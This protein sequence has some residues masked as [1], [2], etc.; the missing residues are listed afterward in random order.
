MLPSHG[1]N[2]AQLYAQLGLVMPK[3][4]IDFSENVNPLPMPVTLTQKELEQAISVYPHPKGEPFLSEVAAFHKMPKENVLLGNGAAEIFTFLA[5][6]LRDK[7]VLLIQ[8]TFSEYEAT[9]RAQNAT[10]HHVNV[11]NVVD[12]ELPMTAIREQLPNMDACYI[13]TPNNPT[14][15][16]PSKEQLT[17]LVKWA[18]AYETLLILDE[19]FIDWI[20]EEHSFVDEAIQNPFVIVVR[21]MTK[22]YKIPG[23]RLGYT[24][25]HESRIQ[26]LEKFASHWHINGIAIAFGTKLLRQRAYRAQSIEVARVSRETIF[27][28][29]HKMGYRY[30]KSETNFITFQL[31]R[32]EQSDAFFEHMLRKGIVLRH[33]KNF[34]GLDGK[35]FRIGMKAAPQMARLET[36]MI[37]W[38]TIHGSS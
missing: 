11:T 16:L 30:T 33:T 36:E 2:P 6:I 18:T 23:I 26:Q 22:M 15:V 28:K 3:D 9:L 20:G 5:S 7:N 37:A 8:P 10:I 24:I 21:S 14:G 25:A 17:Q 35:W 12:Y 32:P 34:R 13:C 27:R 31:P 4:T 19:A 29:L 1:A 38:Q